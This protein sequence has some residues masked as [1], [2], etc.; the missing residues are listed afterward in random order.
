MSLVDLGSGVLEAAAVQVD[1][2]VQWVAVKADRPYRGRDT[3][4][5]ARGEG[6]WYSAGVVYFCTTADN[7]VWAYDVTHDKARRHL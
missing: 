6:A 7:R 1:G 2:T 4:G 5:F 3:T